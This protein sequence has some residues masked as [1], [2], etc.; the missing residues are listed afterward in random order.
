L[1]GEKEIKL[2][3]DY[4]NKVDCLSLLRLMEA[5]SLTT[6]M[7]RV[8]LDVNTDIHCSSFLQKH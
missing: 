1:A 7:L 6:D 3:V 5:S 8:V 2:S 4:I